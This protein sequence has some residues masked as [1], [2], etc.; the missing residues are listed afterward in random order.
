[1]NYQITITKTE[2]NASYVEDMKIW[3]KER[4]ERAQWGNSYNESMR[5]E[6]QP[7]TIQDVLVVNITEEQ[8]KAVKAA[9]LKEFI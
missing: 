8:F 2:K 9:V 5:I 6:P 7:N 4:K 1:M 3:L